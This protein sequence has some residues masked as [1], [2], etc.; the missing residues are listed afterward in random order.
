MNKLFFM[1]AFFLIQSLAAQN[2]KLITGR[3][4][5]KDAT[6]QG[7]HVINLVNEKEAITNEKGEFSILAKPEDLLV[8]SAIHVDYARK[9]IETEDYNAGFLKIEMTSKIIQLDEV[10]IRQSGIDAVSLGILSKPAKK[11]TPAERR[12]KTATALN[13][14]ASVGTMMGAS[15]SLDPVL[16]WISGRTKML[17]GELKVEKK[18]ILLYQLSGLYNKEYYINTLH[19]DESHI[20]GFQYYS[21]EDEKFIEALRSKNKFLIS[22]IINNLAL[23]YNELMKNEKK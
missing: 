13:P 17:K 5:I 18:E 21:I 16:N 7:I 11:Y 1:I 6:P 15:M 10:E 19:I 14:T 9:I 8:F 23:K 22:F 12:L 3:V 2:E 4:L 20:K